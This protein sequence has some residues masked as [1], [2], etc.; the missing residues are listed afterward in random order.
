MITIH[1]RLCIVQFSTQINDNLKILFLS[2]ILQCIVA[3]APKKFFIYKWWKKRGFNVEMVQSKTKHIHSFGM[4]LNTKVTQSAKVMPENWTRKRTWWHTSNP[5]IFHS[6]LIFEFPTK[7]HMP[8]S[9]HFCI[10]N[11]TMLQMF[12]DFWYE[13]I[14]MMKSVMQNTNTHK[15]HL[16]RSKTV[17]FLNNWGLHMKSTLCKSLGCFLC[18]RTIEKKNCQRNVNTFLKRI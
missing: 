14:A 17:Y 8:S 7:C 1:E 10:Q 16:R 9:E 5:S 18:T 11:Q 2:C 13:W 15:N 4:L 12:D 3:I 6:T